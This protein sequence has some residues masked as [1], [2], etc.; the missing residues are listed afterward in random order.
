M[1]NY[2]RL[3]QIL[4]AIPWLVF[5]F[6]HFRYAEIVATLVPAFMPFKLFFAYFTGTAMIAAGI[7][8]IINRFAR[9]AAILL[10]VMLLIFILL[11][12][13]PKVSASPS[14]IKIWTRPLQDIALASIAFLLANK[15]A[16]PGILAPIAKAG[17]YGLALMLIAFG[18]QQF[19]DLDFLT[20]KIPTFLP[21]R[22]V[23]NYLAGAAL[24][25]A[26]LCVIIDIKTRLAAFATGVI[27]LFI[28]LLNYSYLLANEPYNPGLWT[29]V[30]INLAITFGVL[31][32]ADSLPAEDS[33][34]F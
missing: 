3:F 2:G 21:L 10:G 7:S 12:H 25:A 20:A 26:G 32:F 31:I 16:R 4:F 13:V 23:W 30:M 22:V 5:G 28:N 34:I 17:R 24:V 27:L 9:L 19:F 6:Q 8:F 11:I 15:L 1:R 18:I 33:E 29:Q 14:D